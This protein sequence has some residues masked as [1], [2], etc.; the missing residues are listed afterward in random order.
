MKKPVIIAITSVAIIAIILGL[1]AFISLNKEKNSIT[2]S[3]F[4]NNMSQK[5]YYVEDASYQYADYDYVKQIYVAANED[6][7]IEFYELI[8][9]SYA[10]RFYN[11]N[12]TIF[13]ESQ[14]NGSAETSVGLK[15]YSKYTLSSN[16]RYMV[17]SRIDNTV[18]YVDADDQYR[19][20]IKNVLKELG[21]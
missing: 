6:Y 14:G 11:N 12:K 5:G 13:E 20:D 1:I 19:D 15:N 3:S 4:Y 10:M 9:D 2:T 21:Y 8:D 7:Q 18:I 16:G 17:V